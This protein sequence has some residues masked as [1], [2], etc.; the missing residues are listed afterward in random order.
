MSVS[1]GC[2]EFEVQM[3][4]QGKLHILREGQCILEDL[5]EMTEDEALRLATRI[6]HLIELYKQGE[7]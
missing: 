6:L 2:G 7:L 3:D 1:W 4:R 5:G